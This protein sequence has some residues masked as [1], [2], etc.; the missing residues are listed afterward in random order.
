MSVSS[1]EEL[2]TP[3]AAQDNTAPV[4]G[5]I[6]E[7]FDIRIPYSL[8]KELASVAFETP[9]VIVGSLGSEEQYKINLQKKFYYTQIFNIPKERLPVK[10]IA[11][12]RQKSLGEPGIRYYGEVEKQAVVKRKTIPVPMRR[13]NGEDD[14]YIFKV[15]RWISL[16]RPIE[17]KDEGVYN[18]KFTSLFLLKNCRMSYELFNIHSAE[19]YLLIYK[20]KRLF[21]GASVTGETEQRE[22]ILSIDRTYSVWEREGYFYFKGSSDKVIQIVSVSEFA[23]HPKYYFNLMKRKDEI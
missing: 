14:Y 4:C 13:N 7:C 8:R 16:Y 2:Y 9:D 22:P 11:L 12:C 18:P 21:K 15:K 19:Q 10:Y 3:E 23:K 17:I 20:L 6:N 5:K 1:R